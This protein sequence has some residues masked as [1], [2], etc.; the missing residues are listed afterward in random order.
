[1]PFARLTFWVH[2]V[3]R[4]AQRSI[5]LAEVRQAHSTGQARSLKSPRTI[6]PISYLM[7]GIVGTRPL[8]VEQAADMGVQ[9]DIRQYVAA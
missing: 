1:M 7:L 2:A 9:V 3:R 6:R 4:M 8:H 5:S